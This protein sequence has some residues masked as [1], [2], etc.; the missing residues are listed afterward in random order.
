MSVKYIFLVIET[1][2][3][4]LCGNFWFSQ[5]PSLAMLMISG[6]SAHILL[7]TKNQRF[8]L[9]PVKDKHK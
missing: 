7:L 6:T 4:Y 2:V 9:I 3:Y 8:N 5:T 1:L